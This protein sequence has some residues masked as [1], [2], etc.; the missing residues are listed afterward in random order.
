MGAENE[1]MFLRNAFHLGSLGV[2]SSNV[3]KDSPVQVQVTERVTQICH[4]CVLSKNTPSKQGYYD[5]M[6]GRLHISIAIAHNLPVPFLLM[7]T[8]GCVVE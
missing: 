8:F 4:V 5:K 2:L 6:V 7:M 3:C 1:Q